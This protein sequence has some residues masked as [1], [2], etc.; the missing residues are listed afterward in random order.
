MW[1]TQSAVRCASLRACVPLVVT[2]RVHTGHFLPCALSL[3][4]PLLQDLKEIQQSM[5]YSR[6]TGTMSDSFVYFLRAI[7]NCLLANIL[8]TF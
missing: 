4:S 2:D 7:S 8:I 6:I 5:V 1:N 3:E